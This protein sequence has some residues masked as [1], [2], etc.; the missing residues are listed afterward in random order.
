[1]RRYLGGLLLSSF[2]AMPLVV[3]AND[4]EHREAHR[5]QRYYDRDAKDWH[6]WNDREDKAYRHYLEERHEQYRDWSRLNRD[7]QRDYWRWRHE[8]PDGVLFPD[9]R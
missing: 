2:L 7:R 6:E 5:Y 3:R 4:D 8:H 1:M 9:V